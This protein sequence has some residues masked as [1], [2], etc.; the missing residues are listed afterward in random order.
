MKNRNIELNP[1]GM[2]MKKITMMTA[3]MLMLVQ[4]VAHASCKEQNLEGTFANGHG[5]LFKIEQPNCDRVVLTTLGGDGE[6]FDGSFTN[7]ANQ[8]T[9]MIAAI[10]LG[11]WRLLPVSFSMDRS[12]WKVPN[13]AD[14][15]YDAGL[16]TKIIFQSKVKLK[17]SDI[18][19]GLSNPTLRM[20]MTVQREWTLGKDGILTTSVPTDNLYVSL[21][22]IYAVEEPDSSAIQKALVKGINLGISVL[23]K[24]FGFH[25]GEV[26]NRVK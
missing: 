24:I 5:D 17:Q 2:N 11:T 26:L 12:G 22:D 20:V 7:P 3:L 25:Y 1:K 21:S 9:G 15:D 4:N 10:P 6:E 16:V 13:T 23:T 8:I 18:K 19:T 14:R